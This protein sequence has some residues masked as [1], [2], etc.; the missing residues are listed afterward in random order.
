MKKLTTILALILAAAL[1][2]T[3]CSTGG[4]SSTPS[5]AA[6]SAAGSAPQ[7]TG[8]KIVFLQ[9]HNNNSFMAYL[10][11]TLVATAAEYG[12]E[13]EHITADGD[14]AVQLSQD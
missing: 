9:T 10:G 7:A 5:S 2:L 3:A 12:I 11:E 1:M 14:E 8:T 6:G 13:C 4:T